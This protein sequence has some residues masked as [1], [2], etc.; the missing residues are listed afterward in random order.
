M[1]S[2]PKQVGGFKESL[3]KA[4]SNRPSPSPTPTQAS[5]TNTNKNDLKRKRPE[6]TDIVF[7]QPANTGVGE[8][9]ATRIVY[10]L[11]FLKDKQEPKKFEDILS[12]LSLSNIDEGYKGSVRRIL[13]THLKVLYD[14][15]ANTYAYR[16]FKDIRS[17]E[18]LLKFLQNQ[19][20]AQGLKVADL[21]DGWAGAEDAI[22]KLE[23]QGKVLTIRNKKDNHP[24]M[25]WLDDPSLKFP[26]D[27]E[28][29][30]IWKQIKVPDAAAVAAALQKEKL[31]PASK[32]HTPKKVV[33]AP[34][35]KKKKQRTGGKVTNKHMLGILKDYSH[36]S[37]DK[38]AKR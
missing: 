19:P 31:T 3:Q 29:Q 32:V 14:P 34:E 20:T 10:T 22:N 27:Q 15:V 18:D 21:R 24:R 36:L 6:P 25:V 7:S 11:D 28:F 37:K 38:E 1:S 5:S 30:D 23:R 9:I 35:K 2:L 12:Y 17:E 16:A 26:I 33:K 4:S 13:R 8:E